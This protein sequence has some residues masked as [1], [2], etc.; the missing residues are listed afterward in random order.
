MKKMCHIMNEKNKE[1]QQL[2]RYRHRVSLYLL[3]VMLISLITSFTVDS[4][5]SIYLIVKLIIILL[6]ASVVNF[7][8]LYVY[9]VLIFRKK[10]NE[11]V[12]DN[13]YGVIADA[14]MLVCVIIVLVNNIVE[15]VKFIIK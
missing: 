5:Q 14:L 10:Y 1:N 8:G 4:T 7:L 13:K 15:V 3:C 11:N 12:D 9:K 6:I 2:M